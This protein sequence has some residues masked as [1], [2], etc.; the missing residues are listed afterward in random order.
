MTFLCS[1]IC[2][3]MKSSMTSEANIKKLQSCYGISRP[4]RE[5][6][7]IKGAMLTPRTFI[8]QLERAEEWSQ[9]PFSVQQF[10]LL[11]LVA[12]QLRTS[13]ITKTIRIQQP[14]LKLGHKWEKWTVCWVCS[15]IYSTSWTFWWILKATQIIMRYELW[16][17]KGENVF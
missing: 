10:G 2:L 6:E 7:D 11:S 15:M 16:L 4:L 13:I 5:E 14:R 1:F 12:M 8:A 9:R 17:K 3:F